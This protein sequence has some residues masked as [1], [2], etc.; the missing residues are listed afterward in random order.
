MQSK[1]VSEIALLTALITITGA[2]KIPSL[3]PGADFQLSAPLAVAIC[4]VFGFK[5]YMTAGILSSLLGLMLGT[6]NFLHVF[7]ALVFRLV[8]G[9]LVAWG[10][11]H[12]FVIAIAGPIGSLVSRVALS[13][14]IGK[15]AVPLVVAALPGMA[16]T[17]LLA[18]PMMK[19]LKRI[20]MQSEKRF[21]HVI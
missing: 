6:Q 20:K 10:G 17:A 8:V 1:V 14:L 18:V 19:L 16:Y 21:G 4:S 11:K 15:G 9:I 3:L 2:V 13:L 12:L 7:I 5:K